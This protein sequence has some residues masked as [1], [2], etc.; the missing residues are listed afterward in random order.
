M[1]RMNANLTMLEK[2]LSWFAI[3]YGGFAAVSSV[4]TPLLSGKTLSTFTMIYAMVFGAIAIAAS[5]FCAA[6]KP[7]SFALLALLFLSQCIEYFTAQ[8]GFAL[9]GPLP[10]LKLGW[11]WTSPPSHINMSKHVA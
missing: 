10:S 1:F 2:A 5:Y 11:G 8:F 3:G 4:E 9:I 6:A 7:W